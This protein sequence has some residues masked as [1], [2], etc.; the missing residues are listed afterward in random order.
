[1]HLRKLLSLFLVIALLFS[2]SPISAYASAG[3]GVKTS[4]QI[5][6]LDHT[7]DGVR[8]FKHGVAIVLKNYSTSEKEDYKYALLGSDGKLIT[9]Y[10]KESIEY[11]GE[12]VLGVNG[13]SAYEPSKLMNT[14]GEFFKTLEGNWLHRFSDGLAA[15]SK[16]TENKTSGY[17][18]TKGN[19]VLPLKYDHTGDFSE[20]Y[21]Y[22][23]DGS[24]YF[25]V[26]RKGQILK[27][28]P[29]ENVFGFSDGLCSVQL[30]KK[31]GFINTK[32]E[33]VIAPTYD[34]PSKFH[35]GYAV[36]KVLDK[37]QAD[38]N[39]RKAGLAQPQGRAGAP[40]LTGL[41]DKTGKVIIPINN[42]EVIPLSKHLY[43]VYSLNE[44][45]HLVGT[46]VDNT[47]KTIIPTAPYHYQ[48][49]SE[50]YVIQ[51][52]YV[53]EL[54]Q[55]GLVD[56][57]GKTALPNEYSEIKKMVEDRAIVAKQQGS[58]ASFDISAYRY[59]VIN[60]KAELIVP[61]Q[62][63]KIEDYSS[64]YAMVQKNGKWGYID[65]EGKEVLPCEFDEAFPFSEGIALAKEGSQWYLLR[66]NLHVN[67]TIEHKNKEEN[68]NDKTDKSP[69]NSNNDKT[70]ELVIPTDELTMITDKDTALAALK[71]AI[72]AADEQK[73]LATGTSLLSLY[74][75]EAALRVAKTEVEASE[76]IIDKAKVQ[77]VENA[78]IG[79]KMTMEGALKEG[80]VT[81]LRPLSS[82]LLFELKEAGELKLKVEASAAD[83]KVDKLR[84]ASPSY[85]LNF[86][87]KALAAVKNGGSALDIT[88]NPAQQGGVNVSLTRE[89][90]DNIT[91]ALPALG[92][93]PKYQAVFDANG[94]ALGGSYNP[95]TKMLEVKINKSGT[96]TVKENKKSF[97]DI[98]AKPKEMQEAISVLA[99]KGIIAGEG[100]NRFNPDGSITRAEIAALILRAI[101][102][103][104]PSEDGGF[105]DVRSTDWFFGAVGSAKKEGIMKGETPTTFLPNGH[106]KKEEIIAVAARV[107]KEQMNYS[108]PADTTALLSA[109]T[110][111]ASI[112]GW[113]RADAALA[114]RAGLVLK[115]SDG[116]FSPSAKM[117]RGE[118]ALI[119]YRLFKLF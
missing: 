14:K 44:K 4:I 96:Y 76:L 20:G 103:L 83:T 81:I 69:E 27:G 85:M 78:S 111:A 98:G 102:K 32:G 113:A 3:G 36:V 21:G 1:M 17:I 64:G 37:R 48:P 7:F 67:G 88:V 22:I 112:P 114:T 42:F 52:K 99:S 26:D 23:K 29:Y 9:D 18:D 92:G 97:G 87:K 70:E 38:L 71:K 11:L 33:M 16:S 65:K 55:A 59:G 19:V 105:S 6:A 101:S 90:K 31:Y 10:M 74:G 25:V 73:T 13:T 119:L 79:A 46:L 62:Y 15:I 47:N 84:I 108:V 60:D 77:K 24:K 104:N 80:G 58:N 63:E 8:P 100:Q 56:K 110:D 91:L 61:L 116:T 66:D 115:S 95:I 40:S 54:P 50:D 75:E 12:G 39:M 94:Q 86:N 28:G 53:N 93:D 72:S 82:G 34:L 106:L 35:N 43:C 51:L 107:L 89:L 57:A 109:Y 68:R 45:G 117:T 2:L 49:F 30:N 5:L 118:V 41:I